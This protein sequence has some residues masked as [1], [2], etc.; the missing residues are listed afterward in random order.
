[1]M[2]EEKKRSDEKRNRRKIKIIWFKRDKVEREV[3]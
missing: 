1:M 2:G 3:K